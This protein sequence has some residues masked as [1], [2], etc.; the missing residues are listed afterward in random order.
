[1]KRTPQQWQRLLAEQAESS[2]SIVD[3]CRQH[4]LSTSNFYYWRDKLQ[5][6]PCAD[7]GNTGFVPVALPEAN[8]PDEHLV[9]THG[10]QRLLIPASVSPQWLASLMGSLQ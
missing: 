3:F 2:L 4:G 10:Q 5:S 7:L 9:L 6:K 8:K 1:M